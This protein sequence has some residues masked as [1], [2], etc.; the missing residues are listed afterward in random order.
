MCEIAAGVLNIGNSDYQ[1]SPL[2]PY[3]QIPRDRTFFMTA[4]MSF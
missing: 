1:L 4:R 2:T 3:G